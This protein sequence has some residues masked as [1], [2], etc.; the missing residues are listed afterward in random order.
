[1]RKRT[2]QRSFFE[3]SAIV[4]REMNIEHDS[5]LS[6][7]TDTPKVRLT[8]KADSLSTFRAVTDRMSV[9]SYRD[10]FMRAQKIDRES[11]HGALK[12]GQH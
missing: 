5:E 4:S 2:N 10:I 11:A 3:S 6:Q 1:M 9:Q 8:V 12:M 7:E